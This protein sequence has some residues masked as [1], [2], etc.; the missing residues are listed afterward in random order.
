MGDV[1]FNQIFAVKF[2]TADSL[3]PVTIGDDVI[4]EG[5]KTEDGTVS[6]ALWENWREITL[7]TFDLKAGDNII[8]LENINSTLTNLA[9]E[10]YGMNIDRMVIDFE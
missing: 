1:Q 2:G 10:I 9:G 3:A 4:V 5:G 8:E 7:G 6:M